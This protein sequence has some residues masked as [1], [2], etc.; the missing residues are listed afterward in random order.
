MC[1]KNNFTSVDKSWREKAEKELNENSEANSK[2]RQL[3]SMITSSDL[4]KRGRED[5]AFLLRFLR[6]KKFDVDKSFKMITKYYWMKVHS[7]ELFHVSPPSDL[8]SMLEMQIQC[9]LPQPDLQGRQ[10]YL[11]RV[12]M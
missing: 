12:G 2:I 4:N 8:K 7:P 11:F 10:I 5:D 6:A 3:R 9:M 1:A